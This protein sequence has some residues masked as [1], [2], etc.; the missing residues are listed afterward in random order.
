MKRM[1]AA[2]LALMLCLGLC[3]CGEYEPT[4]EEVKSA[5]IQNDWVATVDAGEGEVTE[6]RVMFLNNYEASLTRYYSG[7]G[8]EYTWEGTY[9]IT[10]SQIIITDSLNEID[11][12]IDYTYYSSGEISL[13]LN[14]RGGFG[15]GE[16]TPVP[17]TEEK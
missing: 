1:L 12:F 16:V 5:I 8:F 11:F 17:L 10:D 7:S 4:E 9:E 2:I 6:F 15:E 3:A 13:T 14:D